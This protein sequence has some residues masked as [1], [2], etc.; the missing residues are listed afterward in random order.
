MNLLM[1]PVW[2]YVYVDDVFLGVFWGVLLSGTILTCFHGTLSELW[3][4]KQL[5]Q[6]SVFRMLYIIDLQG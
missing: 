1:P 5:M 6:K 3:V 2:I 4:K